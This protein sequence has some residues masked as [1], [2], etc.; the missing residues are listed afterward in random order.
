M[1]VPSRFAAALSKV[2]VV[3]CLLLSSIYVN[4]HGN[5]DEDELEDMAYPRRFEAVN[6]AQE[7]LKDNFKDRI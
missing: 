7:Y 3:K 5:V 2:E 6:E 1:I 4:G